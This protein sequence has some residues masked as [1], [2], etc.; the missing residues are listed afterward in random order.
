MTLHEYENR[1]DDQD[2][3]VELSAIVESRVEAMANVLA[4][5]AFNVIKDGWLAAPG[6]VF[7]NLI[8]EY[9]LTDTL[10]HVLWVPPTPWDTLHAIDLADGMTAHW[11]LAI[12]ISEPERALLA[13]D[14]YERFAAL[15]VQRD[16]AYWSLA[17][18]PLVS[19]A[20]PGDR[21]PTRPRPIEGAKDEDDHERSD[22]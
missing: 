10:P 8:A 22:S 5:A 12:P 17:R 15:L 2:V 21:T 1:M 4:T 20:P 13:R 11:L 3:R 14:G 19:H 18:E 6:V 9:G 16:T 7:P